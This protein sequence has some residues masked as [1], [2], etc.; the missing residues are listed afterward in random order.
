M[1]TQSFKYPQSYPFLHLL[2]QHGSEQSHESL[3]HCSNVVVVETLESSGHRILE[4]STY[5]NRI[6]DC[7]NT[8]RTSA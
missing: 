8:F 3:E 4:S 1:L 2:G 7:R 6:H 5:S